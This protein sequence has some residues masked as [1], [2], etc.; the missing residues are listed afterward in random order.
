M[1]CVAN[2][3][4]ACP[5]CMMCGISAAVVI[6]AS[7]VTLV[8][9]LSWYARRSLSGSYSSSLTVRPEQAVG[10]ASETSS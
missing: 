10:H 3:R 1:F 4:H 5:D 9:A 2:A 8:L 6:T 7:F